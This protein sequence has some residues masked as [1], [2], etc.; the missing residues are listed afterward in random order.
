VRIR[1]PPAWSALDRT[2]DI[3]ERRRLSAAELRVLVELVDHEATVGE[4][5][6]TLGRQAAEIAC[7]SRRLAVRGLIRRRHG[8]DDVP[9]V[10]SITQTGVATVRPLLTAAGLDP[11]GSR[12]V[13]LK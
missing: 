9:T 7:T 8:P 6:N 5:A 3:L 13:G 1:R 12:L 2:L 4:L 11:R 10:L